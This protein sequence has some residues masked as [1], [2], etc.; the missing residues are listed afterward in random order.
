MYIQE[1]FISL[2][3]FPLSTQISLN[4]NL[5]GRGGFVAATTSSTVLYTLGG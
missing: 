5:T 4:G 2:L 3:L 1:I